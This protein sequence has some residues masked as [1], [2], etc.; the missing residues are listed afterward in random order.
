MSNFC[1]IILAAGEGRRMK[2]VVPKVLCELCGKPMVQYVVEA[3]GS[4]KPK[5][6]IVVVGRKRSQV[7]EVLG[8]GVRV[9][10]QE[11]P[12]GTADAVKAAIKDI[13]PDAKDVIVLYGDTPLI[14]E[15]TIRVLYDFHT[16][17]NVSCTV[18]TTFLD[19]PMGYGRILRNEAGQLVGIIEDKDAN[20]QQKN[21]REINTGMYCFKKADLLEALKYVKPAANTA[22]F[23]LTDAFSWLFSRNRKIDACVV[24]TSQE[25]LGVNSQGQLLEAAEILR[26][27]VLERFLEAGVSIADF[28]TIFIDA[29]AQIGPGTKVL[30]FTVIDKGVCVGK[31]CSIGPFCHLRQGSVLKDKVSVGN[32]TEIKNSY[33]D[34][35]SRVRHVSYIGDTKIGRKVNIG[36]GTV[37]ANFD[38]KKK[39]KTIIKDKAFVGCDTV[40]IAPVVIGKN[41]IVG[42][43]SVVTRDHNVP[44]GALV[45]G[46]PAREIKKRKRP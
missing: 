14:T 26:R 45:V 3:A 10:Y 33:L 27:R 46:V 41:A 20:Y 29:S 15:E 13:P 21:I 38:G 39:N 22:E 4:I 35:S 5:R 12:L 28:K 18:L 17:R 42:A 23:Y 44:D 40:L 24:D 16:S 2:A 19:N 9:A 31:D 36:A 6:I 7:K 8:S 1:V 37:V 11:K 30:P 34:E 43:G 25:V 32:F